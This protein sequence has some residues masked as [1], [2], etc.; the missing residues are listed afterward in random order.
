MVRFLSSLGRPTL[1]RVL[2]CLSVVGLAGL[3][4]LGGAAVMFFHLPTSDFI[5]KSLTGAKAWQ[6]RGRPD[7][8]RPPLLTDRGP[9]KV[10]VDRADKTYDGFT[11]YTTT[12]GSRAT[13]ID[14]WGETVHR[15]EL[16]FSKAWPRPPH[17]RFPVSDAQINWFGCHL[18][19]NGD[20]LAIYVCAQDTPYGYGLVKLNKDSQLVWAYPGRVHHA[21]DVAEDGKLYVLS[22][23]LES[24]P[25]VGLEFLSS[26][27]IADFLVI[28]SPDGREL[29]S[30]PILEVFRKSPYALMVSLIAKGLAPES[31]FRPE[32]FSPPSIVTGSGSAS[33]SLFSKG[34]YIHANTVRVLGRSLAPKFPL[35][36]EG[37]VLISLRNLDLLAVVDV[38]AGSVVWAA[39]GIWRL[40]HDPEF[41]GNGHLLLYDNRGSSKGCRILEYDPVT[42]AVPW[43]YEN[44]NATPFRAEYRGAKQRLRNGNTLITDPDHLR[45]FEVTEGK[46]LVWENFCPHAVP[47][48][49]NSARRY[50]P[51]ELTFLKDGTRPRP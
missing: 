40:Q 1:G 13:L 21:V 33:I 43:A 11:L 17:I 29:K 46:E 39:R 14:M 28:L 38:Q 7:T 20:L 42:Q 2:A 51:D 50:G 35:F 5:T 18:Y 10:R 8:S 36:K 47:A 24:K 22:Q 12:E 25:P 45:I 3:S 41:L 34:D 37:Q 23:K 32:D 31:P 30:I 15:W 6:E 49:L 27:Y 9:E 4:Y 44:E 26:P 48:F 19:P 16:P